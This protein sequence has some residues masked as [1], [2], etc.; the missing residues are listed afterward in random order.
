M[1]SMGD[2]T[3]ESCAT[4]GIAVA[5]KARVARRAIFMGGWLP[6]AA[7]ALRAPARWEQ[8]GKS[9]RLSLRSL[10]DCKAGE[11]CRLGC[12]GTRRGGA[13]Y[14]A[15]AAGRTAWLLRLS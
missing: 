7:E 4:A 10:W 15:Q 3:D 1:A 5:A 2:R 11:A 9:R 14:D 12:R 8:D 6:G 13:H